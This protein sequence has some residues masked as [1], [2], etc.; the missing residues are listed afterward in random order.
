MQ[1]MYRFVLHAPILLML[2]QNAEPEPC[3]PCGGPEHAGVLAVRAKLAE[4]FQLSL[5]TAACAG[6]QQLE[7]CRAIEGLLDEAFEALEEVMAESEAGGSISCI[8]CDPALYLSPLFG[9][10]EAVGALLE[11]RSYAE[12][13]GKFQRMQQSIQLWEGYRCYATDGKRA[14]PRVNREMDARA[15]ITEKCGTN[16][17][18]LRQGLKQVVRMPGDREGCYQS[19]AC[20]DATQHNGQFLEGGFWTYDGEYWYV[21]SKRR[22]PRGDWVS[23][24]P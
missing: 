5:T 12:F 22:T 23:C 13:I 20:R 11:E 7:T 17:E 1:I 10:F 6:A 24:N 9:S 15:M 2:F 3:P 8:R 18:R 19:R 4:A 21:W 14:R 16:F